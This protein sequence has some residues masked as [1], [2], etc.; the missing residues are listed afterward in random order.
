MVVDFVEICFLF[1]EK[2]QRN[3]QQPPTNQTT[4]QRNQTRETTEKL[5]LL[6]YLK[7]PPLTFF[8]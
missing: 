4:H 7:N 2:Y 3:Q 6:G 5:Q 8:V 1:F